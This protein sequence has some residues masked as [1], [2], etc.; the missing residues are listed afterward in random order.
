MIMRMHAFPVGAGEAC[1]LLILCSRQPL[2]SHYQ[3]PQRS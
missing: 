2:H 3:S 1:D